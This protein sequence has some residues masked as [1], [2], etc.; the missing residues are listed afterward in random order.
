MENSIKQLGHYQSLFGALTTLI[1]LP[2]YF[3][4]SPNKVNEISVSTEL[5]AL[6]DEE[7]NQATLEELDKS[8]YTFKRT[9]K[10][11]PAAS[12]RSNAD[13]RS[14]APPE[15]KF[16]TEGYWKPVG[17]GVVGRDKNGNAM[18]GKTWVARTEQ[19][20]A[21][22]PN[23]FILRRSASE[24]AVSCFVSLD[25]ESKERALV[26][27]VTAITALS[28]QISREKNV[29][30]HGIDMEVEFKDDVTGEATG[31]MVYLQ[32]KSGDSH[33]TYRKTDSEKVFYLNE[34]HARYWMSQ[35]FPVLLVVRSSNGN[36]RWMEVRNWIRSSTKE[37]VLPNQIVFKGEPL[38]T[39]AV[40]SWRH[41]F[42]S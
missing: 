40:R 15:M 38:N 3:V 18:I 23:N 16:E 26:G 2:A 4:D 1:F 25:N 28:G 34:R 11:F 27:E 36:I 13:E 12:S 7:D 10:C 9:V 41:L 32:L 33:L 14:I 5:Q 29:S 42:Q 35:R 21:E 39:S 31:E 17:V 37:G 30:D 24:H 19:W 6:A 22:S 8:E 20:S